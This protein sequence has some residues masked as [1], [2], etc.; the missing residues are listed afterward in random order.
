MNEFINWPMLRCSSNRGPVMA[1]MWSWV[2]GLLTGWGL[3]FQF[4]QVNNMKQR[5]TWFVMNKLL[6]S[7]TNLTNTSLLIKTTQP[8]GGPTSS[9]CQPP[10]KVFLSKFSMLPHSVSCFNIW[11]AQLGFISYVPDLFFKLTNMSTQLTS[12]VLTFS[13]SFEHNSHLVVVW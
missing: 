8:S 3:Y 10:E 4:Q 9:H 13:L 11:C 2:V 5:I 1:I 12:D 7:W 6:C